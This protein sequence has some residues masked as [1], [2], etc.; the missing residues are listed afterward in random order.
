MTHVTCRQ[1]V[2]VGGR[3]DVKIFPYVALLWAL[4]TSHTILT[5]GSNPSLFHPVGGCKESYHQEE[6]CVF[7][8]RPLRVVRL[9]LMARECIF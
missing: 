9:Q 4:P 1:V 6:A 2:I 3:W 8:N 7:T 5:V